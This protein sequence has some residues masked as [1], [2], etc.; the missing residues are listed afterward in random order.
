[1]LL[2]NSIVLCEEGVNEIQPPDL[3]GSTLQRDHWLLALTGLLWGIR[4]CYM[5]R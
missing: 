5:C 3:F 2:W 1:M 4:M